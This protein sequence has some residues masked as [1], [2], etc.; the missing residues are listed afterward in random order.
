MGWQ[1]YEVTVG[2]V[3]LVGTGKGAI[4]GK[5]CLDDGAGEHSPG[6]LGDTQGTG[7]VGAGGADHI[8]ADDIE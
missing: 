4:E 1:S 7:G 5:V 2:A 8:G 6:Q 3:A